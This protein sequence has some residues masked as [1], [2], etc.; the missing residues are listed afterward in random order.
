MIHRRT[1]MA[2][3]LA[4][5]VKGQHA[6]CGD[7]PVQGYF[8]PAEESP[9]ARTWLAWPS[10]RAVYGT[11]VAYF[12]DVQETIGRLAAAIAEHE[13]VTMMAAATHHDLARTLCGPAVDLV[14]I[15]T[16]DMWARDNGPIFLVDRNGGKAVLDLNFN[17]WGGKQTHA[18]D[19]RISQ[20]IAEF[21][22]RSYIKAGV[23][24]EAGGLEFDG[25]GTLILTDSC[26]VNDNRNPRMTRSEIEAELKVRLG[27]HKVIWLP[28]VHGE[29]ITDGHIDGSVRFVRPGVLVTDF[30]DGGTSPWVEVLAEC[31]E[32]LRHATDAKGRSFEMVEIPWARNPRSNH[33]DFFAGYANF[34]VGNGAVYT[35]AFGD[36]TADAKA[37][38]ILGRLFPGRRV[39]ALNVDRIYE[40]G[41]GIH[42][43]TQQEPA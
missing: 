35:P 12:E 2:A 30:F 1:F 17:G 26:W 19:R 38:E 7:N 39:V 33:P 32:I 11:S 24:G 18:K 23:I 15:P 6:V 20:S 4:A 42:C 5:L 9:H 27:V 37:V 25:E 16:D 22:G 8:P 43:V 28:G 31:H 34:Y 13:P 10:T 29:D 40:N 21:L 41:G 14:D 36:R 3:M